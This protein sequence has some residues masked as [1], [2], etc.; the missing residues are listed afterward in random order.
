MPK[1]ELEARVKRV[2]LDTITLSVVADSEAE[3]RNKAYRVLEDYPEP[4]DEE[5]VPYCFIE[6]RE[7]C[8]SSI[9]SVTILKERPK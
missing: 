1:Y 3:A 2:V 9:T 8:E 4:H 5:G 7:N 6:D